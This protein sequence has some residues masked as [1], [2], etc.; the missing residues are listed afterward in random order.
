LKEL[1]KLG[2]DG[3]PGLTIFD[4]CRELIRCLR[5]VQHDRRDPNDVATQPH[6]ITHGPD[7][8]R[9]FAQT[10]VLPAQPAGGEIPEE[11]HAMPWGGRPGRGYLLG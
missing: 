11:Q 3:T 9:Y 4:T 1:L 6:E 2:E 10:R 5:A 8:L 7:A